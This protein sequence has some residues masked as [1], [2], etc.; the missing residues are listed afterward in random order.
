M[1]E[2]RLI[3]KP[4]SLSTVLDKSFYNELSSSFLFAIPNTPAV[5]TLWKPMSL[6]LFLF[7]G[8]GLVKIPCFFL[9]ST[10]MNTPNTFLPTI[11]MVLSLCL[12]KIFAL[13]IFLLRS[14]LTFL[15]WFSFWVSI[16]HQRKLYI[17][18][19]AAFSPSSSNTSLSLGNPF[20]CLCF[21]HSP[22]PNT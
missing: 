4:S 8:Y 18:L 9:F 14:I 3:F 15:F 13:S 6:K 11:S 22:M 17:V 7:Q 10:N 2:L 20:Q 5:D 21:T 19:I 12:S 1:S 16:V